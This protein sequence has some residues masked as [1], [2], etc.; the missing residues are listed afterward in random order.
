LSSPYIYK[1]IN[2]FF[3]PYEEEQLQ[4]ISSLMEGIYTTLADMTFIPHASIKRG[5]HYINASAI[6]CAHSPT[7]IRLM[8]LLPYVDSS[9]VQTPD[10]LFGGHFIDYRRTDS[11]DF[12]ICDPLLGSDIGWTDYMKPTSI[13]LTH[14]GSGG[15]NGDRTWVML[16][17][18]TLQTIRVY[19]G[20]YWMSEYQARHKFG[21]AF[22]NIHFDPWDD[23]DELHGSFFAAKMLKAI[24]EKFHSLE[25]TPWSTS[26]KEDGFGV[27][28]DEIK[29]L[30]VLN[31]WPDSFSAD[32]FNTDFIRA[33]HKP[34]GRGYAKQADMTIKHLGHTSDDEYSPEYQR[35]V[36][37]WQKKR[38]AEYQ[39]AL[40]TAKDDDE[41]L[42]YEWQI[43]DTTWNLERS[44]DDLQAAER[45]VERLCPDGVCVATRDLILW[46]FRSLERAYE[47]SLHMD[48]TFECSNR[49][50]DLRD[51]ASPDPTRFD[52]CLDQVAL[53]NHWLHLAYAQSKAE[54]LKHCASTGCE[55]LPPDSIESRAKAKIAMLEGQIKRDEERMWKMEDWKHKIPEGAERTSLAFEIVFSPIVNGRWYMREQIEWIES[56]MKQGGG[57]LWWWLDKEDK[58]YDD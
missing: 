50:F 42:L 55:L 30:L 3:G 57:K 25:W 54:A 37:G 10:W 11:L 26:Y 16:Y 22:E 17:N 15:W 49:L 18:K 7:V 27:P 1:V 51:Q 40:K 21:V 19:D 20:E 24:R 41:R 6:P 44:H 47:K 31:G 36:F 28:A 5:P 13:A 33:K 34:S 29:E 9:L 58:I 56:E 8:E 2:G 38:L 12:S 35:V 53:E 45:E 46:E 23:F 39:A 43:Q 52:S 4:E 32:Q 14:W 48:H